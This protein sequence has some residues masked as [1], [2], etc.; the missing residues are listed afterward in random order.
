MKQILLLGFSLILLSG[1]ALSVVASPV[2]V[3]GNDIVTE[4]Q[5]ENVT[6][7]EDPS[8]GEDVTILGEDESFGETEA[9]T[10][11][12]SSEDG[13]VSEGD[14]GEVEEGG[15]AA[16]ETDGDEAGPGEEEVTDIPPGA[17]AYWAPS[18][19]ALSYQRYYDTLVEVWRKAVSEG[20]GYI[21]LIDNIYSASPGQLSTEYGW[22]EGSG[23]TEKGAFLWQADA[24]EGSEKR[25]IFDLD[26][27]QMVNKAGYADGLSLIYSKDHSGTVFQVDATGDGKAYL[28]IRG[29][30]KPS[31]NEWNFNLDSGGVIRNTPEC[32]IVTRGENAQLVVNGVGIYGCRTKWNSDIAGGITINGGL[33]DLED[34]TVMKC[35]SYYFSGSAGGIFVDTQV[36]RRADDHAGDPAYNQTGFKGVRVRGHINLQQNFRMRFEGSVPD[37]RQSAGGIGFRWTSGVIYQEPSAEGVIV[38]HTSTREYATDNSKRLIVEAVNLPSDGTEPVLYLQEYGRNIGHFSGSFLNDNLYR[39]EG[40][41]Y[42][43]FSSHYCIVRCSGESIY[44]TVTVSKTGYDDMGTWYTDVR[45]AVD[46]AGSAE[47]DWYVKVHGQRSGTAGNDNGVY[48][49]SGGTMTIE[50][51]SRVHLLLNGYSLQRY[52]NSEY[53]KYPLFHVKFGGFL[54]IQGQLPKRPCVIESHNFMWNGTHADGCNVIDSRYATT[55]MVDEGA[56]FGSL[57]SVITDRN[58][59]FSIEGSLPYNLE[60]MPEYGAGIYNE[61]TTV[62]YDN[63]RIESRYALKQGGGIYNSGEL[64]LGSS[65][66]VFDNYAYGGS[67]DDIGAT[68]NSNVFLAQDSFIQMFRSDVVQKDRIIGVSSDNPKGR[69]LVAKSMDGIPTY[70]VVVQDDARY[71]KESVSMDTWF[72]MSKDPVK[73]PDRQ[74]SGYVFDGDSFVY[75][76]LLPEIWQYWNEDVDKVLYYAPMDDIASVF[77]DWGFSVQDYT[78]KELSFSYQDRHRMNYLT[79][80][81]GSQQIDGRLMVPVGEYRGSFVDLNLSCYYTPSGISYDGQ[82]MNPLDYSVFEPEKILRVAIEQHG[83]AGVRYLFFYE[84]SVDFVEDLPVT[85]NYEWQAY[86]ENGSSFDAEVKQV[87]QGM[88]LHTEVRGLSHSA[89]FREIYSKPSKAVYLSAQI[90]DELQSLWMIEEIGPLSLREDGHAYY[91][92][93]GDVLFP[94]LQQFDI[95]ADNYQGETVFGFRY[96]SEDMIRGLSLDQSPDGKWELRLPLGENNDPLGFMNGMLYYL[97]KEPDH[98][99]P[100]TDLQ[101]YGFYTLSVD[102]A[103]GRTEWRYPDV[104]YVYYKPAGKPF[105]FSLP[106]RRLYEWQ[107]E[108]GVT[109]GN[110]G[111]EEGGSSEDTGETE[112]GGGEVEGEAGSAVDPG[113]EGDHEGEFSGSINT[114]GTSVS[115]EITGSVHYFHFQDGIYK[116]VSIYSG[117]GSDFSYQVQYYAKLDQ[118]DYRLPSDTRYSTLMG[119]GRNKFAPRVGNGIL[120]VLDTHAAGM[121][122]NLTDFYKAKTRQIKLDAE[123]RPETVQNLV[124]VQTD[125]DFTYRAANTLATAVRGFRNSHYELEQVW[126][127]KDGCRKDSVDPKDF[128]VYTAEDLGVD[129]LEDV[130]LGEEGS[131]EAGTLCLSDGAVLRMVYSPLSGMFAANTQFYDYN[132]SDGYYYLSFGSALNQTSRKQASQVPDDYLV[133]NNTWLNTGKQGI[134]SPVNYKDRDTEN[135]RFGFGN[136][137]SGMGYS[138]FYNYRSNAFVHNIANYNTVGFCN[139]GEVEKLD[140]NGNILYKDLDVPNLFDEGA[141]LGKTFVDGYQLEF[142]RVGD[143]YTLSGVKDEN[144]NHT[145]GDLTALPLTVNPANGKPYGT[146]VSNDFWPLDARGNRDNQDLLAGQYGSKVNVMGYVDTRYDWLHLKVNDTIRQ[147]VMPASDNG[148]AHNS[149]F[150]MHYEVRFRITDNYIGPMNYLFFGDDDLWVFLD[151]KLIMDVGGVHS[152]IGSYVDLWDHVKKGDT[153]EHTLSVFYLERGSSGSTCYMRFIIPNARFINY[154]LSDIQGAL[155]VEK[156][157]QG[158]EPGASYR[159]QVKLQDA[160]GN[161][162]T[163]QTSYKIFDGDGKVLSE[164]ETSDGN[165]SFTLQDKQILMVPALPAGVT[166]KVTEEAVTDMETFMQE[167]GSM[168]EKTNMLSGTIQ[169]GVVS[170]VQVSNIERNDVVE[171]GTVLPS[172]GGDGVPYGL[173]LLLICAGISAMASCM[174][175]SKKWF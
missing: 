169:A 161:A 39:N 140:K 40:W 80:Q 91:T 134:N 100:I 76:G 84:D 55:V 77:G 166:W 71:Q 125:S 139:F 138:G 121:P 151:G 129:S 164:G 168:T 57:S 5:K 146:I 26:D 52:G 31:V 43:G 95:N 92:V 147:T 110:S 101:D 131:E 89:R 35:G 19:D 9:G 22:G 58:V 14:A 90:D 32:A 36:L 155:Y 175:G 16:D 62:L 94:L 20:G 102:D 68:F 174:G 145:T 54:N 144:G 46:A 118:V 160:D 165:I 7:L 126:V 21:C 2:T 3:S 33:L 48:S 97:S 17:Q 13:G 137:N 72:S 142:E 133:S 119:T 11:D 93:D 148:I 113:T 157:A 170:E 153:S 25:L 103:V 29:N 88:S 78:G 65:V 98:V 28:E 173:Y 73:L 38:L 130:M 82:L 50:K 135:L 99:I 109:G 111:S 34:V 30:Y 27:Y 59:G 124:P 105:T 143:V 152:A 162:Y 150:G 10:D 96:A 123:N 41:D 120:D 53:R 24:A 132:I 74:G 51:G 136:G 85:E 42:S 8:M 116:P 66:S 70:P 45:S 128:V 49:V 158:G 172:T 114:G 115:Q 61:G 6:V 141:A 83:K 23:F 15:S 171:I 104:S 1:N 47:G 81:Y 56:S 159:F 112:T 67:L 108:Y 127:L 12:G 69:F 75:A 60:N 163:K 63:I 64:Y 156:S 154:G 167:V 122:T 44:G 18:E 86:Y 79:N 117:S 37:Y 106:Y 87:Y 4:T 149:F 107:I